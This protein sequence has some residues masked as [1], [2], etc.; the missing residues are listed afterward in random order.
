MFNDTYKNKKVL[1]TGHTGFKGTWL[2][3][4]LK[5]LG[6]EVA[7]IALEPNTNPSIYNEFKNY[8]EIK[9]HRKNIENF[10]DIKKI[11]SEF[12]PDF[13]F[14]LAAQALV[15]ES[16]KDPKKTWETNLV[17]T[18][19][20]LEL[21]RNYE[22]DC[23]AIIIT[24]DKCYKNLEIKRG[25]NEEDILGGDDNYSASKASAE[26]V[27]NSYQ[28]S[29]FC[30]LDN[31][32]LASARA[33]NVIGGGDWSAD[34]IVPDCI[35]S[36]KK[37][38]TVALRRPSSTRPW[39]HVLEPLSGYLQLGNKLNTSKENLDGESFNFGPDQK[40]IKTVEELVFTMSKEWQDSKYKINDQEPLF[41][42]A[43]L[44]Q[45]DCAKSETL[46]NWVPNLDFEKAAKLTIDWYINYYNGNNIYQYSLDQI[47]QYYDIA[48]EKN[49]D[50]T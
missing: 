46:L 1:V 48:K 7:G 50:W 12:K 23:I 19:N 36:W 14:H 24:S 32:K 3:S 47:N 2:I 29:F 37:N 11:I 25:Y 41:K 9:D 31:I 6:A 38:K 4:W 40:N 10:E 27:I 22:Q 26:L 44:L 35:K 42:E 45:L 30:N 18:T 49:Y 17:G 16:Y 13:I 28:K 5:I 43:N 39:Q 34:R 20:I 15:S 8:V 21:L 33:G